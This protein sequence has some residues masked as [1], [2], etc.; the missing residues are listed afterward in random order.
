MSEERRWR[1]NQIEKRC[2]NPIEKDVLTASCC[3]DWGLS[4]RIVLEYIKI[5]IDYGKLEE[6]G[7]FV[8]RK[9]FKKKAESEE[10][11]RKIKK[12]A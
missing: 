1:L 11:E 3:I 8:S 4:R 5:L 6:D 12:E 10:E 9:I 7:D 2:Q